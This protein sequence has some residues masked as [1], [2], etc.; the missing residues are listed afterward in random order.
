[1]LCNH[2]DEKSL[3]HPIYINYTH[4]ETENK[5]LNCPYYKKKFFY[6]IFKK[7]AKLKKCCTCVYFFNQR[8]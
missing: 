3:Q 2:I 4:C 6:K 7:L 8:Y 1:M 5:N